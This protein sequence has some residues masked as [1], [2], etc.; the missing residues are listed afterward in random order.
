MAPRGGYPNFE[1][2]LSGLVTALAESAKDSDIACLD[3]YHSFFDK[4]GKVTPELFLD[5]GLHPSAEGNRIMAARTVACLQ[6][7]FFFA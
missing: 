1:K 7:L 4:K 2:K 6:D 5:D 3:F